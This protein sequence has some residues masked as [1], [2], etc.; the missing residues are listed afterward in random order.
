M[1]AKEILTALDMILMGSLG[2]KNLTSKR[3]NI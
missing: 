1:S 2:R 3:K